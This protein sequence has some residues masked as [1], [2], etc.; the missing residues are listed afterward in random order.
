MRVSKPSTLII[1]QT[2]HQN[3]APVSTPLRPSHVCVSGSGSQRVALW[4]GQS[5]SLQT[6]V[7]QTCDNIQE[8]ILFPPQI[9]PVLVHKEH[10]PWWS[11]APL[12]A[13]CI[14][15]SHYSFLLVLISELVWQ[16]LEHK[17]HSLSVISK[18]WM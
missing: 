15:P 8:G 11:W 13:P 6:T 2:R 17:R 4:R 10:G 7:S 3:H 5:S 12:S 18:P 1:A 9:L 16:L 14:C